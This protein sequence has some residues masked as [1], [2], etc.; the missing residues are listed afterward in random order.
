MYV[1]IRD[2][3]DIYT[4]P[5][6]YAVILFCLRGFVKRIKNMAQN[7]G[8]QDINILP[9]A[10]RYGIICANQPLRFFVITHRRTVM[11]AE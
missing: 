4:S 9:I 5:M 2:E 7:Y 10:I 8:L 11:D 6:F 3:H 1:T